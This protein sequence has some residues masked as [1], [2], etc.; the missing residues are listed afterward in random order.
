MSEAAAQ[1]AVESETNLTIETTAEEMDWMQGSLDAAVAPAVDA[2]QADDVER[3]YEVVSPKSEVAAERTLGS[4]VRQIHWTHGRVRAV[5]ELE[6]RLARA[7]ES[8][9]ALSVE[10][11][12]ARQ[13]LLLIK[14]ELELADANKLVRPALPCGP[15]ILLA[16]L[17]AGGRAG[18][19][20]HPRSLP[21]IDRSRGGTPRR[22]RRRAKSSWRPR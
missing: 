16:S 6:Q 3:S 15:P 18:R 8:K 20:N 7:E 2:C 11:Q 21:V 14:D 4:R 9:E 1:E 17:R 5:S 10:L 13:Q 19:H 22:Q 12:G